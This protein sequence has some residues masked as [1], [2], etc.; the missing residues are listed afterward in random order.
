MDEVKA[1]NIKL[2]LLLP[3]KLDLSKKSLA[4]II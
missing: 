1:A 3:F 4:D 2:V